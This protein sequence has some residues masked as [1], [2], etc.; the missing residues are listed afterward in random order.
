MLLAVKKKREIF[1]ANKGDTPRQVTGKIN[2]GLCTCSFFFS[3]IMVNI[4]QFHS[5]NADIFHHTISKHD[6]IG[7]LNVMV[8]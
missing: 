5:F 6:W 4:A 7:V 3:E 1:C 8:H 2:G